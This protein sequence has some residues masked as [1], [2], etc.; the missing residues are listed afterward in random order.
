MRTFAWIVLYALWASVTVL[1]YWRVVLPRW[2][3]VFLVVTPPLL[4]VMLI[5]AMVGIVGLLVGLLAKA[6]A[7]EHIALHR[8]NKQ[9][10]WAERFAA[11]GLGN[12]GA[13]E[14]RNRSATIALAF[15]ASD[16][17]PKRL[18][19]FRD[20]SNP[21]HLTRSWPVRRCLPGETPRLT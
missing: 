2:L 6:K 1:L 4:W 11:M 20:W 10:K 18:Y 9:E 16:Q 17:L 14:S 13:P 8:H 7:Q 12:Y 21:F 15:A 19:K 5:V 3:M